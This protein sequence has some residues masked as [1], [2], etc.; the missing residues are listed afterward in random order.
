MVLFVV[1]CHRSGTS[2]LASLLRDA[3][4]L[5]SNP[6]EGDLQIALDNPRGFHE[7]RRLQEL[8]DDL[9]NSI[10]CAWDKPPLLPPDWSPKQRIDEFCALRSSFAEQALSTNWVDKDPRL[11]VTYAAYAHILLRRVHLA[12]I[13]RDP[14]E[15]ATSLYLRNAMP[16]ERGLAMWFLYNHHL[17]FHLQDGD[18]IFNYQDLHLLRSSTND[19]TKVLEAINNLL[20]QV[21]QPLVER[22]RFEAITLARVAPELN[23]SANGLPASAANDLSR[24][25]L[26]PVCKEAVAHWRTSAEP[27]QGW[28]EAFG[29]IPFELSQVLSQNQ[30]HGSGVREQP[31][32][33][34]NMYSNELQIRVDN[35]GQELKTIKSSTSWRVTQP[36]RWLGER[37]QG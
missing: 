5:E 26:L 1:G 6:T 28:K 14:L 15:V 8:N 3:L 19:A 36:L 37:L 11:C 9:L 32:T 18:E 21:Q 31:E 12:A 25:M 22:N 24:S 35:L 30:W 27:I 33:K 34:G 10:G 16:I 23:R 17:A 2:L 29:S 13:V 20:S 4:Q 7:S